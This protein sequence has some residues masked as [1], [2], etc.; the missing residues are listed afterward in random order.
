MAVPQ[1]PIT[2]DAQQDSFNLRVAQE[3]NNM[4]PVVAAASSGDGLQGDAGTPGLNTLYLPLFQRALTNV[5]PTGIT[6]DSTYDFTTDA[7]T[8]AAADIAWTRN[9]PVGA[10][11]FVFVT[12]TNQANSA[13]EIVIQPGD[14]S[15]VALFGSPGDDGLDAFVVTTDAQAVIDVDDPGFSVRVLS[16]TLGGTSVLSSLVDT[17]ICWIRVE[18]DQTETLLFTGK[19][20][21]F[22]NS[23]L[24]FDN[25]NDQ[26]SQPILI[27]VAAG[28][29]LG[30]Q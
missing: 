28:T 30:L 27:K 26:T 13:T 9:I 15:T 16:A 3:I 12:S 14:W 8:L 6:A 24:G 5:A 20:V 1:P 25:L 11:E 7:L 10:G 21:M 18:A 2:G 22:S 17:D 23:Q 4:A 29:L 19:N